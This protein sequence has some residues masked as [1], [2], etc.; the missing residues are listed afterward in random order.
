MEA[1]CEGY[2]AAASVEVNLNPDDDYLDADGNLKQVFPQQ[3][4]QEEEEE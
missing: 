2:D 3:Q 4:Q 1:K